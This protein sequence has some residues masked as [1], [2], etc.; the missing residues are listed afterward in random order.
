MRIATALLL[1]IVTGCAGESDAPR[2]AAETTAVAGTTAAPAAA[3]KPPPEPDYVPA[4]AHAQAEAVLASDFNRDKTTRLQMHMSTIVGR[5]SALDGFST[6]V[7]AREEK[8]DARLARLAARVTEREIVIQL[9]GGI[10]FDFDSASL[11]PDA[12]RHLDDL[13]QVIVAYAAA[14]VRIEGHTDSIA[15]DDYNQKLSE[16]RADAVAAWLKSRG[17]PA[18]RLTTVG[19]GESKPAATNDTGEGRQKNRRVEVVIAR[20]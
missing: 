7:T 14:P 2:A 13:R 12:E 10:L 4:G 20:Q 18:A 15:G 16:R 6:A 8:I 5:T 17:I 1:A 11:R 9:P 19:L 3:P